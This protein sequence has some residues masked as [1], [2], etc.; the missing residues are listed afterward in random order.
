MTKEFFIA[1]QDRSGNLVGASVQA[2]DNA[3]ARKMFVELM[4]K[5]G[6]KNNYDYKILKIKGSKVKPMPRRYY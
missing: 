4:N 1:Y 5:N 6:Y 2:R 3:A